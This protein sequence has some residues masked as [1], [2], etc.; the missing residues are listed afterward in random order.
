MRRSRLKIILLYFAPRF[1]VYTEFGIDP[2]D[3]FINYVFLFD[4]K[5]TIYYNVKHGKQVSYIEALE[6]ASETDS[7]CSDS[8]STG[9]PCWARTNDPAVNSRMLYRLS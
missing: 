1:S 7:P 5:L 4:D 2:I 8:C 6:D 9:S 3:T